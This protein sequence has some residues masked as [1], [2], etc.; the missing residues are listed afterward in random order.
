MIV[1]CCFI[2][3]RLK[4]R[5]LYERAL[6]HCFNAHESLTA[7]LLQYRIEQNLAVA[8]FLVKSGETPPKKAET[9]PWVSTNIIG[10]LAVTR[11][12]HRTSAGP[13]PAAATR[14]YVCPRDSGCQRRC[15]GYSS[16]WRGQLQH[17]CRPGEAIGARLCRL[18]SARPRRHRPE[19]VSVL[20]V[21]DLVRLDRMT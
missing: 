1:K 19:E 15:L 21:V 18:G 6:P 14:A 20:V 11:E 2:K 12:D 10:L 16:T 3:I 8:S 7:S 17:H 4:Y 9:R 5:N 13:P